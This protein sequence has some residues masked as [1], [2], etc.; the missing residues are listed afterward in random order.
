MIRAFIFDYGNVISVVDMP[1]FMKSVRP[2]VIGTTP[3]EERLARTRELMVAYE[4]GH[5]TTAD[6]IP[7][8]LDRA[9]LR[10]TDE[11]FVAC[12]S[13]FFV[14]ISFTRALIRQLTPEFR[15]GLL[16]NTNPLH[17]DHV[18]A[19]TDVYPLFDAIT[20]SYEV[21]AMKPDLRLFHD[22]LRKLDIPPDSCVYLD[23][24]QENVKAAASLGMHA[25]HYTDEQ[26]V[27]GALRRWLPG[28]ALPS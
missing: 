15:L 14:P 25:I 17:F 8:F 4:S 18:I 27:A 7:A 1:A 6:F 19:Q 22:M 21:G 26:T 16:S 2:F 24:L 10:M 12:W 11:E 5:M 28:L 9:G 23:D 3:A 20:L 13:G